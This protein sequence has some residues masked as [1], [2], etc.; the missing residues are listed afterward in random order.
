[1]ISNDYPEEYPL[2]DWPT[3]IELEE[4][5]DRERETKQEARMNWKEEGF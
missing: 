2:A 5:Q 4:M 3:D 1:M